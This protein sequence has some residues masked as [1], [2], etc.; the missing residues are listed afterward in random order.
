MGFF[1]LLNALSG[2]GRGGTFG[3]KISKSV[4]KVYARSGEKPR[5]FRIRDYGKHFQK[6]QK[7]K[8]KWQPVNQ[9][10]CHL[11]KLGVI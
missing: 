6:R 3:Q 4:K 9:T 10:G 11:F 5:A 7:Q 2:A 8:N 1:R